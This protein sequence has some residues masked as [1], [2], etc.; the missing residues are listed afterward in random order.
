MVN[1]LEV[2]KSKFSLPVE[3]TIEEEA[4]EIEEEVDHMET[5][6][7]DIKTT[8][9]MIMEETDQLDV[10]LEINPEDALIAVKK[11]I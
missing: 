7:E 6:E 5:V 8:G 4:L 1:Q 10:T 9:L 3:V 2:K 11:D